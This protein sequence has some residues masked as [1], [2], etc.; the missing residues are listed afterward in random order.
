MALGAY[1]HYNALYGFKEGN[2][3]SRITNTN[4][5]GGG[6]RKEQK[7]NG[8]AGG[9][10]KPMSYNVAADPKCPPSRLCPQAQVRRGGY[11]G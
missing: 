4:M 3:N 9:R 11:F 10:K 2:I 5:G 1:V 6:G 8:V 7:R